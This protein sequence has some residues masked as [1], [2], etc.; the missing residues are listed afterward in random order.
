MINIGGAL[1]E[2]VCCCAKKSLVSTSIA[3]IKLEVSISGSRATVYVRKPFAMCST[4]INNLAAGLTTVPLRNVKGGPEKLHHGMI[5]STERISYSR[6]L[7]NPY[8]SAKAPHGLR[9]AGRGEPLGFIITSIGAWDYTIPRIFMR[10][11]DGV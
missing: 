10:E 5:S 8:S 4:S 3:R 1:S 7:C 2:V 9:L 11:L 6:P